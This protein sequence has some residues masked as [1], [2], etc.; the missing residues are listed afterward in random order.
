MSL[1]VCLAWAIAI[2]LRLRIRNAA[3]L[4]TGCKIRATLRC[5]RYCITNCVTRATDPANCY[6]KYEKEGGRERKR[7]IE[8][9]GK[10]TFE[11]I[12]TY[13]LKWIYA[14]ICFMRKLISEKLAL[15]GT[16][17]IFFFSDMCSSFVY[18][19]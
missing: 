7:E 2:I 19:S 16:V 8:T 9:E 17:G 5:T 10:R 18:E 14:K 6:I 12:T 4:Q 15:L 11:K 3:A 13:F 1:C